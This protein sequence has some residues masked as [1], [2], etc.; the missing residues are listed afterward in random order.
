MEK[1]NIKLATHIK[2]FISYVGKEA[3][4]YQG[5]FF[6]NHIPADGWTTAEATK[7]KV[8]LGLFQSN[9]KETRGR[10]SKKLNILF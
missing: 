4:C 7:G 9:I 10:N 6:R 8:V 5:P 1:G 3:S 2:K